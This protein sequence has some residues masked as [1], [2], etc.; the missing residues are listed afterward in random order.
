MKFSI[1]NLII[2]LCLIACNEVKAE[3]I[4][5][6]LG[7]LFYYIDTNNLRN[8]NYYYITTYTYNKTKE[9]IIL[10]YGYAFDNGRGHIDTLVT[11]INNFYYYMSFSSHNFLYYR[12]IS[13]NKNKIQIISIP[14]I[15]G[16]YFHAS[17]RPNLNSDKEFI[18]FI[19]KYAFTNIYNIDNS[20]MVSYFSEKVDKFFINIKNS[21]DEYTDSETGISFETPTYRG[22][23]TDIY[24]LYSD[25][26]Y[27]EALKQLIEN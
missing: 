1:T 23:K 15:D 14:S 18:E 12:A 17:E 7:K 6:Y 24:Q 25:A 8:T 5:N 13:F 10:N 22:E 20:N 26:L 3:K 19:S 9:N 27:I 2:L 4:D 11:N 16:G 21:D